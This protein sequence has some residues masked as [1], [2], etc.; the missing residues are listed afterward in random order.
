MLLTDRKCP[1]IQFCR[2]GLNYGKKRVCYSWPNIWNKVK[3]SSKITP[4]YKDS[5][6][7]I[8][9]FLMAIVKV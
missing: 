7:N 6:S 3:K 1:K 4:G 9:C 5:I 2:I 8:A